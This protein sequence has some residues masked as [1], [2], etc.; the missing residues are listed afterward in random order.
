[1]YKHLWV[2]TASARKLFAKLEDTENHTLVESGVLSD[3]AL[4]ELCGHGDFAFA[5]YTK[6][7]SGRLYVNSH[8]YHPEVKYDS[9]IWQPATGTSVAAKALFRLMYISDICMHDGYQVFMR[10]DPE[11]DRYSN[12]PKE[13]HSYLDNDQK[14]PLYLKENNMGLYLKALEMV[15]SAVHEILTFIDYAKNAKKKKTG[16]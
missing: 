12:R 11:L 8:V 15:P 13:G 16:K 14:A 4:F 9:K 5:N 2:S 3:A 10:G 6:I 7:R 1:M